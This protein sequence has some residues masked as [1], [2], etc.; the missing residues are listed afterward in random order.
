M[1]RLHYAASAGWPAPLQEGAAT[2]RNEPA[3]IYQCSVQEGGTVDICL[4]QCLKNR[5]EESHKDTEA[6]QERLL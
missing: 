4:H 5:N 2:K 1:E 6:I 3:G